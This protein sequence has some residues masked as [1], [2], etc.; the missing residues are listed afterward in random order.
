MASEVADKIFFSGVRG[1]ESFFKV[2]DVVSISADHVINATSL[3]TIELYGYLVSQQ[4]N[5]SKT[6]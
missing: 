3:S 2:P 1:G 5:Y 4:F 6:P